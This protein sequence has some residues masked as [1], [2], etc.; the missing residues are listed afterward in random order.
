LVGIQDG[1]RYVVD[2]TWPDRPLPATS[3]QALA[4][5]A[6]PGTRHV[7]LCLSGVAGDVTNTGFTA[8]ATI[9]VVVLDRTHLDGL[10]CGLFT[11]AALLDTVFDQSFSHRPRLPA[12]HRTIPSANGVG[13]ASSGYIATSNRPTSSNSTTNGS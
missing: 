1:H 10:V 6:R 3:I 4:D 11:P 13:P 5:T 12:A 7:I 2:I 9:A 8:A